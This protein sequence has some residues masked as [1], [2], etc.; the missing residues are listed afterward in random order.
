MAT[1][2]MNAIIS[3]AVAV[4]FVYANDILSLN[5]N[6]NSYTL[7]VALTVRK[8]VSR[9]S[10][11][12]SPGHLMIDDAP[13]SSGSHARSVC[14]CIFYPKAKG[15]TFYTW[16]RFNCCSL[17][18]RH[19]A[20]QRLYKRLVYC[21]TDTPRYHHSVTD[22]INVSLFFLLY[23]LLCLFS[24]Y[25]SDLTS[26]L[27]SPNTS[28]VYLPTYPRTYL[29]YLYLSIHTYTYI[30]KHTNTHKRTSVFILLLF[31]KST[32]YFGPHS[33][34]PHG[35]SLIQE[36]KNTNVVNRVTTTL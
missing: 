13:R 35:D 5:C 36:Y 4:I 8:H 29:P 26:L 7:T 15:E 18:I 25:L 23:F 9:F 11:K 21:R 3:P 2:R 34:H 1:R 22:S 32:T 14:M 19:R 33:G 20:E 30:Q 6:N 27:V 10:V 31:I 16:R 12:T 24:L 17:L 28:T